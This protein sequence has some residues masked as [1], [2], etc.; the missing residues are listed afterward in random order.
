MAGWGKGGRERERESVCVLSPVKYGRERERC[1]P[2]ETESGEE[3]RPTGRE[4]GVPER[5]R[6]RTSFE[7]ES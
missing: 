2:V 7:R 3:G 1:R 6:E 4:E 5:E